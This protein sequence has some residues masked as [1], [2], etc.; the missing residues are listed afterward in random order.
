M[1]FIARDPGIFFLPV[2]ADGA[3]QTAEMIVLSDGL[4]D[5]TVGYVNAEMLLQG[6]QNVIFALQNIEVQPVVV[7]FHGNFHVGVEEVLLLHGFQKLHVFHAP[8]HHGA[9]VGGKNAVGKVEA[10][11][12]RPFQQCPSVF[13]EEAGHVIGAHF[14]GAG[15]G[16][17]QPGGE[18]AGQ[19]QQG[20]RHIFAGVGGAVQPFILRLTDQI[21]VGFL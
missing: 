11:L 18:H 7:G 3:D 12:Q 15:P 21:V 8:V 4:P 16:C 9:A 6:L 14:H 13:A 17:P 20:L 5:G 19:V 1:V 10:A 2:L